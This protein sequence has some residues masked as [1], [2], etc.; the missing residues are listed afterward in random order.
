MR[1]LSRQ[2]QLLARAHVE[3]VATEASGLIRV[4]NHSSTVPGECGG[5]VI[6]YGVQNGISALIYIVV[7]EVDRE[8]PGLLHGTTTG[9]PQVQAADSSGAVACN[10]HL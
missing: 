2:W 5:A 1:I 9:N 8:R 3:I 6:R 7:V 10:D 4:K